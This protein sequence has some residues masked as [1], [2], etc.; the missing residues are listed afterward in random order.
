VPDREIVGGYFLRYVDLAD[1]GG[2]G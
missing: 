2:R 1:A